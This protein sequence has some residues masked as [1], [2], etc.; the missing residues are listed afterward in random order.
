MAVRAVDSPW[1]GTPHAAAHIPACSYTKQRKKNFISGQL[2]RRFFYKA[3]IDKIH[4]PR[5]WIDIFMS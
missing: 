2:L 5:A 1:D 4:L 3:N